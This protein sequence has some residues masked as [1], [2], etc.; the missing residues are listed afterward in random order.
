MGRGFGLVGR[1]GLGVGIAWM[2]VLGSAVVA[3]AST[4]PSAGT[5]AGAPAAVAPPHPFAVSTAMAGAQPALYTT[6]YWAGAYFTGKSRTAN[7]L[8]TTVRVPDAVPSSSEFYYVLLS[9][10]DNAGSYD[11]IGFTNDYGHWGFTYSYTS[12]CAGTYYYNP[13][14]ATLHRGWSY[15]FTMNLTASGNLTFS[16]IHGGKV[17]SSVK[18]HTGG[19]AFLDQSFYSCNSVSY[20]DLTDYEESYASVQPMPSFDYFFKGNLQGNRSVTAWSSMGAPPGGGRIVVSGSQVEVENE[21]FTLA[22]AAGHPDS[23][24]LPAGSTSYTTSL[25]VSAIFAGTN[26]TL[27]SV[28]TSGTFNVSFAPSTGSPGFTAAVNLTLLSVTTNIP[29]AITLEATDAGGAYTY[30]TLVLTLL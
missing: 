2:I 26:V 7:F 3:S 20:Y 15:N 25:V 1:I 11:Q 30:V 19:S 9:V 13:S 24:K 5:T 28:G 8:S 17:A 6:H 27:H 4:P 22:F 16:A 14:Q 10:W 29:Y 12:A 21:A 23:V 18:K